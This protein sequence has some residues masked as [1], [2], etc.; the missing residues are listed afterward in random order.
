META[1]ND[2][3]CSYQHP[4]KGN[5]T[6]VPARST[7]VPRGIENTG[8]TRKEPSQIRPAKRDF[9]GETQRASRNYRQLGQREAWREGATL[10]QAFS[11]EVHVADFGLAETCKDVVHGVASRQEL[12]RPFVSL[13]QSPARL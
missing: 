7:N 8:G 13:H 9:R 12:R 1:N 3:A 11:T 4:K 6:Q 5:W 2:P 10:Y